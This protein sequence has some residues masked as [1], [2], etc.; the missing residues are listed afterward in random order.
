MRSALELVL[1][2]FGYQVEVA[3]DGRAGI[4][5]CRNQPPDVVVTDIIMP[6]VE[7]IA[8]IMEIKR[9]SPESRIIAISGGGLTKDPD[10]YLNYAA[11]LGAER[12]LTKPFGKDRL[13]EEIQSLLGEGA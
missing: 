5:A 9:I 1:R 6:E 11:T 12:T 13:I 8:A 2:D 3:A 4:E 10:V 7:G